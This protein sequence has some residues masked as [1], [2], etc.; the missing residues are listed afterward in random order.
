RTR[1]AVRSAGGRR[2][3]LDRLWRVRRKLRAECPDG[4]LERAHSFVASASSVA[5]K[6]SQ[7]WKAQTRLH[8]LPNKPKVQDNSYGFPQTL[9]Y[10]EPMTRCAVHS[11]ANRR[12]K[13]KSSSLA[14]PSIFATSA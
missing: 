4:W 2:A 6:S 13:S 5:V 12:M 3:K 9:W 1:F 11:A 8:L 10:D 14:P 7:V